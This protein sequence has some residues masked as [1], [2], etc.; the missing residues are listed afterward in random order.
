MSRTGIYSDVGE[1]SI[2]RNKEKNFDYPDNYDIYSKDREFLNNYR[3]S[4]DR[5]L[6]NPIG[7]DGFRQP[8]D[9]PSDNYDK[10]HVGALNI[11]NGDNENY[12]FKEIYG[13]QKYL[14]LRI[15]NNL[16]MTK[17][18]A[19]QILENTIQEQKNIK[20][21]PV[22][23]Y[24]IEYDIN[25]YLLSH[26]IET[27][28]NI[29]TDLISESSNK[30]QN[31]VGAVRNSNKA[32]AKEVTLYNKPQEPMPNKNNKSQSQGAKFVDNLGNLFSGKSSAE[33]P[34]TTKE[35]APKPKAR[36]P[37][38]EKET[39]AY[40][41]QKEQQSD[42]EKQRQEKQEQDR[43]QKI[44]EIQQKAQENPDI[45]KNDYED[46]VLSEKR[47]KEDQ[48][49]KNREEYY[50]QWQKQREQRA[51]QQKER[52]KDQN[53]KEE[54]TFSHYYSKFRGYL[55]LWA[56]LEYKANR[57]HDGL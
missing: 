48:Q 54:S 41:F 12:I 50:K 45:P 15:Q 23:L 49:E 36:K 34:Q 19:T 1:F 57:Y 21:I 8:D 2:G 43:K 46:Y 11:I 28:D 25:P 9:M 51:E 29:P 33:K 13:E 42:Y 56:D 52:Y 47:S 35:Q 55:D 7:V 17:L 30:S 37:Q 18:R 38:F 20:T 40:E 24:D 4:M 16:P 3:L 39:I 53:P 27:I 5:N 14:N 44:D 6:I 31:Y 22:Q 32:F 26:V 10:L